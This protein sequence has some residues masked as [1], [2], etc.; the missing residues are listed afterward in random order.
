M[1]HVAHVIPYLSLHVT[2]LKRAMLYNDTWVYLTKFH[3]ALMA[4]L[5]YRPTKSCFFYVIVLNIF[6]TCVVDVC[7]VVNVEVALI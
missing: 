2:V 1:N 6:V 4:F 7:E 5:H 3:R